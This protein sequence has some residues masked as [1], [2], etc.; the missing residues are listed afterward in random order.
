[1]SSGQLFEIIDRPRERWTFLEPESLL[2]L[3]SF[4][5]LASA[6]RY[7]GINH[8]RIDN[9]PQI[10]GAVVDEAQP[11]IE[12]APVII[13]NSPVPDLR[14]EVGDEPKPRS[15]VN[16]IKIGFRVKRST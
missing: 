14:R 7:A 16:P 2:Y 1:L 13:S 9:P 6:E 15:V 4:S 3:A 10:K 11:L 5:N 12:K 8:Y